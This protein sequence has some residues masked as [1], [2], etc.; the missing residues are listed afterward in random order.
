VRDSGEIERAIVAFGY[1]PKVG[2]IV[3]GSAS[4]VIHR[5]QIISL[6]AEHRLPAAYN[7]RLLCRRRHLI[8]SGPIRSTLSARGW[9]RRQ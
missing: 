5:D 9:L 8:S 3:P 7:Y 2:L 1:A 4:A 6:A